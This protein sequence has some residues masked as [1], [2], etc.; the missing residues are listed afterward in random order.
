MDVVFDSDLHR[1]LSTRVRARDRQ[2]L[3]AAWIEFAGKHPEMEPL[4]GRWVTSR[5]AGRTPLSE[6][7]PWINYPAMDFLAGLLGR[8]DIVFE[9]GMGGSTIWFAERCSGLR[10]TR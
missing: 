8:D 6:H 2:V 7:V 1:D 4:R 3:E 9:W 5:L 10:R